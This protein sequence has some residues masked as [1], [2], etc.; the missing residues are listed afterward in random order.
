[1]GL[2]VIVRLHSPL[3]RESFLPR[4]PPVGRRESLVY[5]HAMSLA[6]SDV[7]IVLAG[8]LEEEFPQGI[9]RETRV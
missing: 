2:R 9:A 8:F 6:M 3:A 5:F 4:E 1:M 7:A